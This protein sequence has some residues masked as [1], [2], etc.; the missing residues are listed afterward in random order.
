[1]KKISNYFFKYVSLI[2]IYINDKLN[3]LYFIM[4]CPLS[5]KQKIKKI[6]LSYIPL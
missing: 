1:M 4:Y 3:F 2:I 5:I 6:I